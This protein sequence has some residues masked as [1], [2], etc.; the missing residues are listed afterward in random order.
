[1]NII[2]WPDFITGKTTIGVD[3]ALTIG[4]F[5]GIHV[6]HKKLFNSITSSPDTFDPVVVTF[7]QNPDSILADKP[8]L[9]NILSLN[10]KI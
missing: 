1:M 5:D 8:F 10:Q 2:D 6:G 9:G 7:R 4:V 3:T